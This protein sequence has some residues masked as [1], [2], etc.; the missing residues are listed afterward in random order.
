M[1]NGK[2][3]N[4]EE[5]VKSANKYVILK[6]FEDENANMT[7]DMVNYFKNQW[8]IDR[9]K[10]IKEMNGDIEDVLD[11][12]SNIAKE[13]STEEIEETH[14]KL[15]NISKVV[16]LAF[17]GW[18]WVSNSAISSFGCRIMV[19][20]DR[21]KVDL[22]VVHMTR[23]VMVVE[24]EISKSKQKMF[25]SFVYAANTG[26]ERR[27]LWDDLWMTKNITNGRTWILL[28]DFN[29]TLKAD[30]HSAGGS[31]ITGDMKEFDDVI[32]RVMANMKF[33]EKY[34]NASARFHPFLLSDHSPA[35]M[36]ILNSLEKKH[37]SFR[38]SN[39]M[40]DK[41]DEDLTLEENL[42]KA[43]IAVE[44]DPNNKDVKEK[45]SK[46][47]YDYNQ[48][49]I[50]EEKLLSQKIQKQFLKHFEKFLGHNGDTEQI[51]NAE[52]LFINKISKNDSEFMVRNITNAEIKES[53]FGIRNEKAHGPDGFTAEVNATLITL[54]PKTQQPNRVSD[55]RP[56]ACCNVIYK[57]IS[58]IITNR[59][60]GCLEKLMNL[61][62]SAFVPGRL[63]QDNILI[64]QELLKG[65]NRQKGPQRCALKIDIAKAY[66]TENWSFLKRTLIHFG[67]YKKIIGWIMTCVT[68]VAFSICINGKRYGYFKSGRGIRQWDPMSPYLFTLVMEVLSLI[69][70]RRVS[71]N[72]K[73]IEVLKEG[74]MEFSKISGLIP[75]MNKSTIFFGSVKAIEKR[76][77]LE[78][79]PFTVGQL[80][81]KY[82]G[83]PLITKNI[84]ITEFNQLVERVKQKVNDWKS[85]A[86]SYA[87]RLQLIASVLASMHIYWTSV[88]LIPKT[89]VED[90]E[91]VLKGFLWSQ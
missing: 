36:N 61:N 31:K 21:G 86:L 37:K 74:L 29:V 14:V 24:I 35:V 72:Y 77:N 3:Q 76:R 12:T 46:I 66:D 90:I 75:N 63:I 7:Q 13:L 57:C 59:L 87:G 41:K 51:E 10:E 64:T 85:K 27:C 67:F 30:E 45:M 19:G 62:Q 81:M 33:I 40:A 47:L 91:K 49:I 65:Y 32:L 38:F 39:Y 54:V 48:A 80:P 58:K 68:S 1:K 50:D 53:I 6:D 69:I 8:E 43:Q 25:C 52:E 82:L 23:Q 34:E 73:S 28:G 18:D 22:M 44:A 2:N 4:K 26:I 88:F 15:A 17:G 11:G 84:G 20:W 78:I 79:M 70:Q 71:K 56:I 9:Q 55:Y 83:V 42:K 5:G 16:D 89:T 60:Q